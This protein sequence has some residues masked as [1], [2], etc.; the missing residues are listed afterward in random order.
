MR[1]PLKSSGFKHMGL[2]AAMKTR[3]KSGGIRT[4]IMGLPLVAIVVGSFLPGGPIAHQLLVLAA[5]VWL[6]MFMLLEVFSGS[7]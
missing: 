3:K 1:V 4:I 5:I 2:Q 7:G 6:Q